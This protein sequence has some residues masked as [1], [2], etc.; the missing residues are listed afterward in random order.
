MSNLGQSINIVLICLSKCKYSRGGEIDEIHVVSDD[1][2]P[3]A[4]LPALEA[5]HARIAANGST[6]AKE[7]EGSYIPQHALPRYDP[8]QARHPRIERGGSLVV[9]QHDSDWVIQR[10]ILREQGVVV[11]GP[12]LHTLIDPVP[13]NELRR[14]VL[15]TLHGWWAPM[16]HDPARLQSQGYQSYAVLTMCR[17][18]YTLQ[19]G[20]VVSKPVAA[21]WAQET[22]GERWVPL[23]ERALAGRHNP[24]LRAQSDDVNGTQ[25]F[26]RYT[27]ERSQQFEMPAD[28]A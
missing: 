14:A 21:R 17:M 20:A 5:M 26:I 16:I 28:E 2:L 9:E 10:H 23:V 19:Y 3:D 24:Q 15:A 4:L 8:S 22:L 18:L 7:L 25:D 1:E 11:A 27:L 6:W 13:P 12:D